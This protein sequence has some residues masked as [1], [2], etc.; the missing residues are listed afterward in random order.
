MKLKK[1]K[2]KNK[3]KEETKMSKNR[4]NEAENTSV[5]QK[6]KYLKSPLLNRTKNNKRRRF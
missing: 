2:N 6:K 1:N 5:S 3:N 4:L